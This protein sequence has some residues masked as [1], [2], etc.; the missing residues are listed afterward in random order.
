MFL[1]SLN[2]VPTTVTNTAATTEYQYGINNTKLTSVFDLTKLYDYF[3]SL[4]TELIALTFKASST[5]TLSVNFNELFLH[6][7]QTS[8]AV[9][10]ATVNASFSIELMSLTVT[11]GSIGELYTSKQYDIISGH[12]GDSSSEYAYS[13]HV[14]SGGATSQY[15]IP[16]FKQTNCLTFVDSSVSSVLF[17]GDSFVGDDGSK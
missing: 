3:A 9:N 8:F 16:S 4:S 6:G 17:S 12:G 1:A 2:S 14:I 13:D 7:A 5:V 15:D 11:N 10:R